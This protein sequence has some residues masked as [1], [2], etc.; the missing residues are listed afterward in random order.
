MNTFRWNS[1]IEQLIVKL[2][3]IRASGKS[4][5]SLSFKTSKTLCIE[6]LLAFLFNYSCFYARDKFI[7]LHK[8]K[9]SQFPATFHAHQTFLIFWSSIGWAIGKLESAF[10]AQLWLP[11][12]I[13]R[14]ERFTSFE[15][16]RIWPHFIPA[17]CEKFTRRFTIKL[18]LSSVV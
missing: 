16:L 18:N 2:N 1:Y 15:R 12:I 17:D 5:W 13:Y 11:L 8:F 9:K 14:L 7:N 6:Y 3:S 10:S 4:I